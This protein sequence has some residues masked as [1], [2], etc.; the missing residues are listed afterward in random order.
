MKKLYALS[1]AAAL[2]CTGVP[3]VTSLLPAA[4]VASAAESGTCGE[5]LNWSLS[6]AGVLTISGTGEMTSAPWR[7]TAEGKKA[8]EEVVIQNGVESI[9]NNAFKD[10][11]KLVSVKIPNSVK[12]IGSNAFYGCTA[13]TSADLPNKLT[14][15]PEAAFSGCS[16]LKSV[17]IPNSVTAI[18]DNAFY[19]CTAL[20]A[21]E[22][23]G[24]LKKLGYSVFSYSGL[25]EVTVPGTVTTLRSYIFENCTNLKNA[26]LEKGITLVSE[27]MFKGCKSLESVIIPD[28]VTI[29]H[30][31]FHECPALTSVEFP[32]SVIK[33]YNPFYECPNIKEVYFYNPKCTIIDGLGSVSLSKSL[34]C[35]IYGYDGSTAQTYAASSGCKFSSLGAAPEVESMRGD[36]NEDGRINVQDA[37]L[38][39][40]IVTEDKTVKVNSNMLAAADVNGDGEI[41]IFDTVALLKQIGDV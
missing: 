22:L 41:D 10:C 39:A 29:V 17:S 24:G 2:L 9:Y 15:I 5:K 16:S 14:E 27:C 19:R 35:T 40:R 4:Y 21:V 20:S 33:V 23:P 25:K 26:V 28:T 34:N 31:S 30:Y 32:K 7:S 13:L 38:L 1:M 36:L 3:T 6:S 8:V 18:G 37:I 12:T 11:T